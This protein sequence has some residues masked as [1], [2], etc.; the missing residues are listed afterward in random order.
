MKHMT[1]TVALSR[2]VG[3]LGNKIEQ[4]S[5]DGVLHR[6]ASSERGAAFDASIGPNVIFYFEMMSSTTALSR[7][8]NQEIGHGA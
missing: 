4:V 8:P 3:T 5:G 7:Q 1:A 6:R 2:F